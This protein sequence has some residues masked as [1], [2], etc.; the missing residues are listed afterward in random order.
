[1]RLAVP[2]TEENLNLLTARQIKNSNLCSQQ[3]DP[4]HLHC[5]SLASCPVSYHAL[6]SLSVN[7]FPILDCTRPAR[8]FTHVVALRVGR[9]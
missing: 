7:A 8:A 1:M 3:M 5:S 9:L 4:L 6:C 2:K